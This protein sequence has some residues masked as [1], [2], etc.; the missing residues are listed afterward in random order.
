MVLLCCDVYVQD[1][2]QTS[3]VCGR[4]IS[5]ISNFEGTRHNELDTVSQKVLHNYDGVSAPHN[6]IRPDE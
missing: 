5:R 6:A 4:K 1:Q 2:Q 3:C